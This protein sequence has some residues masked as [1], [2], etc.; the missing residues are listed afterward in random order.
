MVFHFLRSS[1]QILT[2]EKEDSSLK[3]FVKAQVR[4]IKVALRSW[5]YEIIAMAIIG[6]FVGISGYEFLKNPLNILVQCYLFGF[7]VVDNYQERYDV[8]IKESWK[9]NLE[10]PG[11]V[12]A[13]GLI[14]YILLLI[15]LA[16]P[17]IAP[18]I[19]SVTAAI[20]F[21][22]M[23]LRGWITSGPEEEIDTVQI[24]IEE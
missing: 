12:L 19:A 6:V 5:I 14:S 18:F 23:E 22:E 15:P 10:V 8:S 7:I 1:M 9:R 20:T 3:A 11:T 2:G 4:M 17:I 13:I 16:G 24:K 21:F